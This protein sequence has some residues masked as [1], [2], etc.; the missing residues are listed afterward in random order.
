MY[1]RPSD[2]ALR[3]AL[4]DGL[5][6]AIRDGSLKAIYRRYGLWNANQE[7]LA[8]PE[9]QQLSET[10]RPTGAAESNWAIVSGN[11]PLLLKAAGM[12]ILLSLLSMPLAIALGLTVALGRVYGPAVVRVPLTA[13][14]E[15]IRGTPLLLQLYFIHFGVVPSLG[16]PDSVRAFTPVISAVLGLALNYA[17]YE[18][19]IYRAGLLAIP[20]GQM[21]AALALGLTRGQA[22]WHVVV[23]QAVRLVIPPVTNDFINLFKDTSICSVIAVEEL[24]KRYNI[25]S[26]NAPRAFVELA[27]VTAVLYLAMSYPLAL[28]TRRLEKKTAAVR[29]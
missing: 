19:E 21:E 15:V 3:D 12:T 25:A 13:Y 28:L 14:V 23:P 17:A 1:V 6:A 4:N 22:I 11:L 16:L 10:Q 20:V 7:Q 24:T 26:N 18:A 8:S 5:R 29:A 2:A 27:L 9:V